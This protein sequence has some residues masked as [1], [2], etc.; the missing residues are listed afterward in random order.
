MRCVHAIDLGLVLVEVCVCVDVAN[1]TT[2]VNGSIVVRVDAM[3]VLW[4]LVWVLYGCCMA[5]YMAKRVHVVRPST[6]A[7][8]SCNT[9]ASQTGTW[10]GI[11]RRNGG[12]Q[13]G[14]VLSLTIRSWPTCSS[15]STVV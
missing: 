7:A 5:Q 8:H 14:L 11:K 15:V 9:G 6:V 4:L 12:R 2:M 3:L 13:S 10:F 1:D